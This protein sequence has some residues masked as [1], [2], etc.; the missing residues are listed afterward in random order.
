MGLTFQ[1]RILLTFSSSRPAIM[2]PINIYF[3]LVTFFANVINGGSFH[4]L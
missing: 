2:R 4:I 1:Y 3:I